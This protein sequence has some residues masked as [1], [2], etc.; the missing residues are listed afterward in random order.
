MLEKPGGAGRN[1][2]IPGQFA[3]VHLLAGIANH[4]QKCVIR[5]GDV[6]L[7]V[8][9]DDPQN[10]GL[11]Q[12]AKPGLALTVV[13]FGPLAIGQVGGDAEEP[14][15]LSFGVKHSRHREQDRQP[16]AILADV[17]PLSHIVAASACPLDKGVKALD[18]GTKLGRQPRRVRS[19]LLD[20]MNSQGCRNA[21]HFLCRV[22]QHRARPPG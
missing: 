16:R 6:A 17:G 1:E 7:D 21:D 5:F 2:R 9:K 10:V 22:P 18:P 4:L 3:G 11:D 12:A 8:S 15:D 14:V 13:A 19:D 20:I